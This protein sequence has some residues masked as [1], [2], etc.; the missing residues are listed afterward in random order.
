MGRIG[1][2]GSG[3]GFEDGIAGLAGNDVEG[4]MR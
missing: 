1:N 2:G 3:G 4:A